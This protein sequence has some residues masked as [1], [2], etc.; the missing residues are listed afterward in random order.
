MEGYESKEYFINSAWK[1]RLL[2]QVREKKKC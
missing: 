1:L 2:A